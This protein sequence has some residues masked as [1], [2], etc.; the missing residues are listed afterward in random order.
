MS[1]YL[2]LTPTKR[3][4]LHARAISVVDTTTAWAH[5]VAALDGPDDELAEQ[6]ATAAASEAAAGRLPLAATHLLWAGDVS[7]TREGYEERLLTAATYLMLADEARGLSLREAVEACRPSPLRSCVLASMAIDTGQL[8]EAEVLLL[9]AS[10][11]VGSDAASAPLAAMI[12]NRLAGVYCLLARGIDAMAAGRR[13]LE[14]GTMDRAAASQ[15]RTL[16]AIGAS[17]AYGAREALAE[18]DHLDSDPDR[19]QAVDLD[20][21]SFRGVFRPPG[22]RTSSRRYVTSG[23]ASAWFARAPPSPSVCG[24]TCI[25]PWPSTSAET[26]TGCC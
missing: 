24:P 15:T 8:G 3:R 5:R 18:L 16:I 7:S 22:G 23:P 13:A 17:Q 20:A 12:A 1:I 19:I 2:Q 25:S 6:L 9:D 11:R 4:A 14:T 10:E 26:G 21:L